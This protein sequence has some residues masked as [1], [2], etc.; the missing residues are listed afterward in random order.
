MG[1]TNPALLKALG[2]GNCVLALNTPFNAEVIGDYGLLFDGVDDL[3]HK[4]QQVDDDCGI[5]E[6]YRAKAPA[7]DS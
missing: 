1:G 2:Y 5:V 6:Q 7:K 3:R 4:L